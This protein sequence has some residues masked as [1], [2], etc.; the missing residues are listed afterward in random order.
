MLNVIF[1][2]V[3]CA[4]VSEYNQDGV[5]YVTIIFQDAERNFVKKSD[6][7]YE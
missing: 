2:G 5:D 3:T 6:V 4:L 1:Q 7:I